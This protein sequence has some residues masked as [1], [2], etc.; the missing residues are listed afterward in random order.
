MNLQFAFLTGALLAA[1]GACGGTV[2]Q[3]QTLTS[4]SIG[5]P[6]AEIE[7]SNIDR[8][9]AFGSPTSW[10]SMCRGQT[11]QCSLVGRQTI[12]CT[13]MLTAEAPSGLAPAPVAAPIDG[14]AA[15]PAPVPVEDPRTACPEAEEYDKKAAAATSPAREQFAKIAA[16]KHRDCDAGQKK[17]D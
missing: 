4:G 15:A 8:R 17:P 12:G 1:T 7:I 11:F 5:C 3:L 13:P 9:G 10:Q 14:G 6:P 2:P 16:H